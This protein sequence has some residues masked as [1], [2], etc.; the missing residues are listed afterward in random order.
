[1]ALRYLRAGHLVNVYPGGA[2]EAFK[3]DDQRYQLQWQHSTG[4]VELAMRA[5]VPVILHMSI[6]TDDTYRVLAK[7]D[8]VGRL[9]GHPKYAL[10]IW[11]GWGPL[12]RPVKF[13]T[14]F[15]EPIPLAGDPDD[16]V[17]VARNHE[18]L[19][20]RGH[21]MLADGLRHRRSEWFG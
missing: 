5:G 12:P 18:L 17:A 16:P 19:W 8:P 21:E 3:R 15:S 4:F 9:L 20:K 1:V 7:I 14:Y 10:P 6:G 11:L 13:D 2:R